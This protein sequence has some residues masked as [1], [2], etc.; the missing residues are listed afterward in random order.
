[1]D[2]DLVKELFGSAISLPVEDRARYLDEACGDD[3]ALRD[4][5][6]SL[7]RAHEPGGQFLDRLAVALD[8]RGLVQDSLLENQYGD[9]VTKSVLATGGMGV[10]LKAEDPEGRSLVIKVQPAHLTA[11]ARSQAR[12]RREAEITSRLEHPNLCSIL[13]VGTTEDGA[14]FIVMPFYNGPT[15]KEVFDRGRM[16]VP[17]VRDLLLTCADALLAAHMAGIVHRDIKP[18]NIMMTESGPIILDF[19]VARLLDASKL[20]MTGTQLGTPVYMSPE[21]ARGQRV[22]HRTDI[23]SLGIV[24]FEALAGRRP[25]EGEDPSDVI[26]QIL[27]EEP[28]KLPDDVPRDLA[29]AVAGMMQKDPDKRTQGLELVLEQLG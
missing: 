13:E 6:G 29:L 12:F 18:S 22:D 4:E 28:A 5:L 16:Q 19:G 15:L 1:M 17:E 14:L 27:G 7:L 3:Q 20:T 11:D 23:W 26:R 8:G 25:F 9:Y 24:A 10:V 21:Q 2:I